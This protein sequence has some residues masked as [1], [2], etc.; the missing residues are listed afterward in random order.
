[1]KTDRPIIILEKSLR[2]EL[3]QLLFRVGRERDWQLLDL[4][5][6]G[7]D[8]PKNLRPVGAFVNRLPDDPF[9]KRLQAAGCQVVRLGTAAH[10]KDPLVPVV[11]NDMALTGAIA[12]EHFAERCFR[13]MAFIGHRPWGMYQE[14]YRGF[15]E[16]AIK[17]GCE[18]HEI[19]WKNL[20][21]SGHTRNVETLYRR[22]LKLLNDKLSALPKPLG[23][24]GSSDNR[25]CLFS[26]M[27][28]DAE[29]GVP[30]E[31]GILGI[32][33]DETVC[34]TVSP[35]MSSIALDYRTIAN[36]AVA[37]LDQLMSGKTPDQTTILVPPRGVVMRQS[38]YVFAAET[39]G[40]VKATRFMLDHYAEPISSKE[41]IR[42]S[43][44]SRARLFA[45][46]AEDL[47]QPPGS[48]L[49]RIRIDK[50]KDMLRCSR[51]KVLTIAEA[52]GFGASIN[53]YHH[54]RKHEG[55]SPA[56]YRRKH[57]E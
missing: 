6:S 31:V 15:R 45:A 49:T 41:I 18:C 23:L 40:V 20:T 28:Q 10:P 21:P 33:N 3:W 9:V 25:A 11:L 32:G 52:C 46:F 51:E 53:M 50:A 34:E 57:T 22:R 13:H 36:K 16:R 43:G 54:F 12:A 7:N 17:L 47:G 2:T 42:A 14:L 30:G 55:S 8:I 24:L 35:S 4:R 56:A 19:E 29:F 39:P 48:I 26:R 1:M 44:M 5:F 37:T 38:T 27:C